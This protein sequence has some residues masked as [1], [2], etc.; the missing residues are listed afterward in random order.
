ML[1]TCEIR[2]RRILIEI[3]KMMLQLRSSPVIYH[4]VILLTMA[5]IVLSSSSSSRPNGES[6]RINGLGIHSQ[7]P[8]PGGA[9]RL[10]PR[11]M[12]AKQEDLTV[13][14]TPSADLGD[15]A[16]ILQSKKSSPAEETKNPSNGVAM[17]MQSFSQMLSKISIPLE[18]FLA[19][20]SPSQQLFL[21]PLVLLVASPYVAPLSNYLGKNLTIMGQQ[22]IGLV[23]NLIKQFGVVYRKISVELYQLQQKAWGYISSAGK[24]TQQQ[25]AKIWKGFVEEL[26]KIRVGFVKQ[27]CFICQ[28]IAGFGASSGN[29]CASAG[30]NLC[31]L[32]KSTC[33]NVCNVAS[34][35]KQNVVSTTQSTASAISTVAISISKEIQFIGEF[36]ASNVA[37]F[38]EQSWRFGYESIGDIS[39]D[40]ELLCKIFCNFVGVCGESGW[41]GLVQ[42]SRGVAGFTARTVEFLVQGFVQGLE[43][44]WRGIASIPTG[45]TVGAKWARR[46]TP[47]WFSSVVSFMPFLTRDEENG[48]QVVLTSGAQ[49]IL[50]VVT[51]VG[52]LNP[53]LQPQMAP[54]LGGNTR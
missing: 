12:F 27:M 25:M 10:G 4:T 7:S 36:I 52:A 53:A 6:I 40:C 32:S 54:V 34:A 23:L 43:G 28:G 11:N 38:V 31:Q 42:G 17:Q 44:T 14:K 48:N 2:G 16:W 9:I 20:L 13:R 15:L 30:N 8:S 21:I 18:S 39:N 46:K 41:R 5:T 26:N 50:Y 29:F 45:I 49:K 22:Y 37:T 3:I 47:I 35:T 19:T 1:R 33:M 51:A 24:Y